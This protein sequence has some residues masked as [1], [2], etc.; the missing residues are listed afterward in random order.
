MQ[1][2]HVSTD[3]RLGEFQKVINSY[4]HIAMARRK[5]DGSLRGMILV[6]VEKTELDGK[7]FNLMTVNTIGN[8][9]N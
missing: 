1:V 3:N 2:D 4:S 8:F 5:L 7:K 9:N 6:K